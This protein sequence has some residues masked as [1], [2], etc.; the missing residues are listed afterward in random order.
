MRVHTTILILLIASS[1]LAAL[2][3]LALEFYLYWQY[4]WFD[5]PMH[6]LGGAIVAIAVFAIMD[7]GLPLP[8]WAGTSIAVLAFVLAIGVVWEIFEVVAEISTRERNYVF[9]TTIDLVMDLL[10]GVAGYFVGSRTR[11]LD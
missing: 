7:F 3:L 11:E 4:L 2:H 10:G 5:L 8:K 6:F 1:M 9:D